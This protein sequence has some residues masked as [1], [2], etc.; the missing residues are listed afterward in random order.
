MKILVL[1]CVCVCVF[2]MVNEKE[3]TFNKK[4]YNFCFGYLMVMHAQ[5]AHCDVLMLCNTF[6]IR[7]YT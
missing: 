3:I 6:E 7:V 5:N 4:P 2:N 1:F